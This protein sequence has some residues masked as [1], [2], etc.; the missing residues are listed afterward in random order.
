MS[1]FWSC[2]LSYLPAPLITAIAV[3]WFGRQIADFGRKLG[4]F[5][6][7]LVSGLKALRACTQSHGI[8][9]EVLVAKE[10]LEAKELEKIQAP[11]KELTTEAI[12]SLITKIT[13]PMTKNEADKLNAFI[14]KA[15]PVGFKVTSE[16]L[17]AFSEQEYKELYDTISK[18][19][20]EYKGDEKTVLSTIAMLH[21]LIALLYVKK[22]SSSVGQSADVPTAAQ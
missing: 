14:T 2:I 13:N 18:L 3:I 8:L 17:D 7:K 15:G 1:T 4:Q 20:D 9:V 11:H 10:M 16:L 22:L 12:S 6:E 19:K 5:Q 21:R